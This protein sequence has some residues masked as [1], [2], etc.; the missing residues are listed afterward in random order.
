M[1]HLYMFFNESEEEIESKQNISASI[2]CF[3]EVIDNL[4]IS[5]YKK[6]DL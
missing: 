3:F 1:L 4:Y 6:M 2:L 5:T